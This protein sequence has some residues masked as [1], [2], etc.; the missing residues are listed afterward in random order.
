[1]ENQ[2]IDKIK[3]SCL[4]GEVTFEL[5]NQFKL[6]HL[7][8]CHQCQK[9]SGSAHVSNLFIKKE[10]INWL[11]GQESVQRYDVPGRQI[12][13]V[14]CKTCGS[15]VPYMSGSGRALIV[16]A[17]SLDGEPS[18]SPQNHIYMEDSREWHKHISTVDC[19]DRYTD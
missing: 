4:C 13:N 17:G 6:F 18:L 15:S 7:C 12:A 3:G 16:P 5:T 1:M 10:A 9:I 8:H 11:S 14:F 19:F 2:K